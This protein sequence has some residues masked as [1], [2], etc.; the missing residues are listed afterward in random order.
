MS[1]LR[2]PH[3]HRSW[4]AAQTSARPAA[5]LDL[6]SPWSMP[7]LPKNIHSPPSMVAA[8]WPLQLSMPATP[9]TLA[10]LKR[11]IVNMIA[12]LRH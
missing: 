3:H 10:G 7:A 8:L 12:T 2:Q 9:T 6:D 11:Q 5:R 1:A 4:A